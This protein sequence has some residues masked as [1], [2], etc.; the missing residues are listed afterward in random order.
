MF[1]LGLHSSKHA[2]K[3][4]RG[5]SFAEAAAEAAVEAL[6]AAEMSQICCHRG[7]PVIFGQAA[8]W[9][10]GSAGHSQAVSNVFP[11]A[12]HGCDRSNLRRLPVEGVPEFH[13]GKK[14]HVL[15]VYYSF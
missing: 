6:P 15:I 7:T 2:E 4:Q 14:Y 8:G 13:V 12:W 10:N 11:W 5:C 1:C 9:C 3:T